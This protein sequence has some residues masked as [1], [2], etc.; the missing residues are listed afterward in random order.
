MACTFAHLFFE[1][2]AVEYSEATVQSARE[3]S[4]VYGLKERL[5]VVSRGVA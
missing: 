3:A 1:W 2:I 5:N 4:K